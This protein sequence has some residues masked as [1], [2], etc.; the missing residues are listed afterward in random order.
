[1]V[2]AQAT[3]DKGD[4]MIDISGQNTEVDPEPIAHTT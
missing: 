2:V 4:E 1:M 3:L